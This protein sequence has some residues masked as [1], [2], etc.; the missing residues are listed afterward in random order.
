MSR[1]SELTYNLESLDDEELDE[2]EDHGIAASSSQ[3]LDLDCLNLD[4]DDFD[5][6]DRVT[7]SN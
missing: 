2:L 1:C 4:D 6:I 3:E 5:D 7:D